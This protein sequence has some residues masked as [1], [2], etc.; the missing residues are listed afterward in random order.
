MGLDR[1]QQVGG[2][3]VVEE[4]QALAQPPQRRGPELVGSGLHLEDVVRQT[5]PHV[6]EQQIRV[7]IDRLVAKG[8]HRGIARLERRR[9]TEGTAHALEEVAAVGDRVGS[10]RLVR[11]RGRRG[12][13]AHEVSEP[14]HPAERFDRTRRLG[15]RD[16]VGRLRELAVRRLIP[17]GLEELVADAHL[18]VV[19]LAREEKQ[20][21]V[22][23]LPAKA[24][25]GAVVAVHVGRAVERDAVRPAA[26]AERALAGS[27]R[28]LI[29][30][31]RTVRDLLDQAGPE[32]RGGNPEDQIARAG[33][34]REVRLP[35]AAP[36]RVAARV[37]APADDEEGVHATVPRPVGLVL[38]SRLPHRPVGLHERRHAV[39]RAEGGRDRDL[40]IDRGARAADA[41]LCVAPGTAIQV[42][43]R[44]QAV[45]HAF[46][47]SEILLSR[48]EEGELRRVEAGQRA[49]GGVGSTSRAG[50]FRAL[51]KLS[52]GC[53]HHAHEH[54]EQNGQHRHGQSRLRHVT[55]PVSEELRSPL[56]QRRGP[57]CGDSRRGRGDGSM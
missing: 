26:D 16:V 18:D 13:E 6:V 41:T 42:E 19:G 37:N 33:L 32:D 51:V 55:L 36:A 17:L 54:T 1:F 28:G 49:A 39:A 44:P 38:E 52:V 10:A 22:L 11:R 8:C 56:V 15:V 12:Q 27:V 20:R 4:E 31:D 2:T 34:G 30:H 48:F 47:L 50:I 7:E 5:R 24:R 40:R 45:A 9:V 43:A 14:L 29:R 3:P 46:F 25:D 21:L 53:T 23:G 35:D 57:V